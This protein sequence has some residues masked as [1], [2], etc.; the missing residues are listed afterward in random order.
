MKRN[1][2]L[3]MMIGLLM[4]SPAV[5]YAGQQHDGAKVTL[6]LSKH[7]TPSPWTMQDRYVDQAKE[8]LI[9]GGKNVLLGWMELYNE[10]RDAVREDS[11]LLRGIG[12]GLV[13]MLGDTVGGAIHLGT[14]PI[15]A[16]DIPLPEGGTD[17]L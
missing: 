6:S 13:N 14:F 5:S 9:Y 10:P 16:F 7:Y 8:K 3:G 4:A 1:W 12:H 17:I 15:T 11:G 2:M